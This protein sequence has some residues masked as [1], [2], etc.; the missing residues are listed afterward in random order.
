MRITRKLSLASAGV[1]LAATALCQSLPVANRP[2]DVGFSSQRLASVRQQMTADVQGGRIPGAV[3]LIARNGKIAWRDAVGFQER[4]SQTPMR[5]DSIF[6]I[7]SMTKPIT[8]VAAMILAEEGKLD[9]GAPVAQYLPEFKDVQVGVEH[10]APKRAM[11]VQDLMRHTSG[12]TYGIFGNSPV[13]ELYKKSNFFQSKSLAEM[14]STIA[15]LPL[16]HQ[17]GEFWE[18]SV[19]TDV[20][21][22]IVEV[23]GGMDLDRFIAARITGPLKMA[24][25]GFHLDG[26]QAARLAHPDSGIPFE[27]TKKPA[28]LSGGGAMLSTAGDYVR[29]CQ[30]MLNGGELDGVRILAPKTVALMTA[31]QLPPLTE[32][33]TSVATMLDNFG[34]TP[35]MGTSF[36]LGFAVRTAAG[37]NPAPGS[38]G[39]F[40]WA[41]IYGTYFWVDPKEKLAAV[42]MIQ[43]PMAT[44]VPYWRQ[45]RMLVYQALMD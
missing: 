27:P 1:W 23:V 35:E 7:A 6:R 17:P 13:D 25:S 34:P 2:E 44:N 43:V 21:G 37:R 19:S 4:K 28:I 26:S 32:R 15:H 20:L 40:S 3:L 41:G 29:F 5:N 18:Y 11:T 45:T 14:V 24:D 16:A 39:D 36:G 10:A 12:L 38:V 8:T 9:V 33:H 22:R 42:L 30:M 31:D